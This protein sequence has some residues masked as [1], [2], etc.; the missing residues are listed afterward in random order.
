MFYEHEPLNRGLVQRV[1]LQT[2]INSL[3]FQ[4]SIVN[5]GIGDHDVKADL[6]VFSGI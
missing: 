6:V 3:G 2:S 5:I 4:A 1:G